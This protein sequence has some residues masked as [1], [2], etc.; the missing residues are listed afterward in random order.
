MSHP[1]PVAGENPH[2]ADENPH[3]AAESPRVSGDRRVLVSPSVMCADQMNLGS[4]VDELVGLGID[5][6][7]LD[8]MDGHYV[9]NLTLGTDQCR[10]LAE[11]SSVPLDI[12][13]MVDDPGRWVP[14]FAGFGAAIREAGARPGIAIDP[15][16]DPGRF[17]NLFG[18][19]EYVLLMT[20][21]PGYSGQ[22]LVPWGIDLIRRTAELRAAGGHD[23]LIEVDGNVS[24]EHIPRM[25]EAGAD[26]LVAGTSSLFDPSMDRPAAMARLRGLVGR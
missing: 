10:A 7:H 13:L 17:R 5:W 16:H 3:A 23:F 14:V 21:S 11:R 18:I 1:G 2:A 15:A 19:V 6:L 20:V 24:W 4:E 22:Q 8:I 9:P 26:V 25:V 12:H